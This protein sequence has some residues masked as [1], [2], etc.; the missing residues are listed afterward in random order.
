MFKSSY[1]RLSA[2]QVV[3]RMEFFGIIAGGGDLRWQN[4]LK[5]CMTAYF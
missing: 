5:P 1:K 3:N 2:G 4:R